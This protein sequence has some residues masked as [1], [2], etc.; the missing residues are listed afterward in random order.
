M[1]RMREGLMFGATAGCVG[2]MIG[3]AVA[4]L[5]YAAFTFAHLVP[6][7]SAQSLASLAF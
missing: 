6:P 1:P 3:L 5:V 4:V 2:I 7:V